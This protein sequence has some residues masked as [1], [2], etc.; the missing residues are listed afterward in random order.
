MIEFLE[1]GRDRRIEAGARLLIGTPLVARAPGDS[2]R[3]IGIL[4][5]YVEG[6]LGHLFA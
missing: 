6:G 3:A 1:H 4:V 2:G 5:L